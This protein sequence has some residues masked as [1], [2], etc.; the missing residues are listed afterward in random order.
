MK[1][2][3]SIGPEKIEAN[4]NHRFHKEDILNKFEVLRVSS[5]FLIF[6]VSFSVN[7]PIV[8]SNG[9]RTLSLRN[10]KCNF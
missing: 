10:C 7:Q 5:K 9:G 4:Y 8:I 6:C 3:S 2:F 1:K